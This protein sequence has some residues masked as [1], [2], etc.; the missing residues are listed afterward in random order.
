MQ[1]IDYM[2]MSNNIKEYRE[3]KGYT[4]FDMA[5]KMNYSLRQYRRIEDEGTSNINTILSI[6]Y[7]LDV[8]IDDI[9]Y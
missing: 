1:T 9:I 3:L 5:E 8:T 6:A 7:V 4:Q 2:K